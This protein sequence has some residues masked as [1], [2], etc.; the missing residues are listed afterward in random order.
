[1]KDLTYILTRMGWIIVAIPF[2]VMG[3]VYEI[4]ASS[5]KSGRIE[6][7]KFIQKRPPLNLGERELNK[8]KSNVE[9]INRKC[10]ECESLVVKKQYED[11]LDTLSAILMNKQI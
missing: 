9:F 4:I 3:F 10:Q 5:F 6:A 2:F 8:I 7:E 1:M 11:V